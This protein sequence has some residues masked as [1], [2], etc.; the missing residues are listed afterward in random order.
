MGV[1]LLNGLGF[2]VKSIN[3]GLIVRL[4]LA[5]AA[6]FFISK[7]IFHQNL[8]TFCSALESWASV[9]APN[10]TAF[11]T[12]KLRKMF[13]IFP[14]IEHPF[15][16][17][18]HILAFYLPLRMMK[19]EDPHPT[20]RETI[21]RV[22]EMNTSTPC[23]TANS[24]MSF[25]SN[26][27]SSSFIEY[28]PIKKSSSA[29][30][31][32]G[33]S[34]IPTAAFEDDEVDDSLLLQLRKDEMKQSIVD[35]SMK[36]VKND[37]S[38]F[39]NPPD[40]PMSIVRTIPKIEDDE[41]SSFELKSEPKFETS[42]FSNV[43]VSM[44]SYKTD[45]SK[46]SYRSKKVRI[47]QSSSG[48]DHVSDSEEEIRLVKRE[49]MGDVSDDVFEEDEEEDVDISSL[50]ESDDIPEPVVINSDEDE[51]IIDES[52]EEEDIEVKNPVEIKIDESNSSF[53]MGSASNPITVSESE[54]DGHEPVF[55]KSVPIA[56]DLQ[57]KSRQELEEM[58]ARMQKQKLS[59]LPDGGEKILARMS[60]IKYRLDS[61]VEIENKGVPK[62]RLNT[63][64]MAPYLEDGRRL[65][66]GAMTAER[67]QRV[68]AVTDEA[69]FRIHSAITD[70]PENQPTETPQ[71][72]N[73]DLMHHQKCGLTWMMFRES[74][75]PRGGI[76]ADDMGLGKTLSLISLILAQKNARQN[77][78]EV[79]K[80]RKEA[81]LKAFKDD[82][83][84]VAAFSTLV[85]APASVIFQWEKEIKDR[86]QPGKLKT[87]VFH[88]AK[89][90]TDPNI[91]GRYDIVITTYALIASELGEKTINDEAAS[92]DEENEFGRK[93][94]PKA[95]NKKHISKGNKSVLTKIGW[96]RVILDEAHNI[97]N[98]KSL[99][100]KGC[101]RLPAYTRWALT[102]TPIH[103]NLM[104]FYSLVKFLR[105]NPF[106]E[107]K[108]WKEFIMSN[109]RNSTEKLN[110]LVK[111]LLL[112]RTK[113]QTC[114]VTQKPLVGLKPKTFE[115]VQVHL[116]GLEEMCYQQMFEASKQKAKQLIEIHGDIRIRRKNPNDVVKNPFLVGHR[117]VNMSDKFQGMSAILMLLLRLRQACVHMSLTRNAVDL[118]AFKN[119]G[120]DDS[121]ALDEL[122][123]TFG[124]IS[125][126][127]AACLMEEN[128][129]K[130]TVEDI[131]LPTFMSSKI[132]VLCE[133]LDK[134]LEIGDKCVI[135]SQWTS[136]L[137]I[138]E[139]H[140]KR[141]NVVYTSIT[142][143][144]LTKDRQER[145]DCFNQ[146]KGGAQVML[147]S[148]T[149]GGVGL[150][151]VGGNHLFLVDLHW[152]PALEQQACDRIYR[153]G[154]EK[155]VF[156]HKLVAKN[157]IEQR[158]L[159]LQ[160]EKT[161]LAKGVLEGAAKIPN[162]LSIN[163][164]KHLFDLNRP[165]A[166]RKAPQN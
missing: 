54:D 133:K 73:V 125:I 10:F 80:A 58:L 83:E 79:K 36:S 90:E 26:K 59:E 130:V 32:H 102:G 44:Q 52:E 110:A 114:P 157:T 29:S 77:S 108:M 71:G 166:P 68:Q 107:E 147:L 62:P 163:D 23:K 131:F 104:D 46:L 137:D 127:D 19:P 145:V 112:R 35:V 64:I 31:N 3:F 143:K 51:V 85:V 94:P 49:N 159:D 39:V 66:G 100:S 69:L 88:G 99:T 119:D 67:N 47:S 74:V 144:V 150:N 40:S 2:L 8:I 156:I 21:P 160:E 124:N 120:G 28:S 154:Q 161:K 132:K 63:S 105:V 22:F 24:K 106:G 91:L 111:S 153:V 55:I 25:F 109:G 164:L 78:E 116:Q 30:S 101:C 34:N 15:P 33:M 18:C 4:I 152:N 122:E 14:A 123:K 149:A 151:L 118:D 136:M 1:A 117:E 43:D 98:H 148:L 95:K 146:K 13:Q 42:K 81:M 129:K 50:E 75:V 140:L 72:L 165:T 162:K 158:V 76:L 7:L 37:S 57:N 48:T 5:A 41:D 155:D 53:S 93:K 97:K 27:D 103:N 20:I 121:M 17:F 135:V 115:V 138:V 45:Q 92:S 82:K 126:S 86:V 56:D 16:Y 141:R 142:G 96:E 87:Y 38:S 6:N 134:V 9:F 89:R 128:G 60:K 70:A 12:G 113:Q 65:Y 11:E 84:V 61:M 139:M